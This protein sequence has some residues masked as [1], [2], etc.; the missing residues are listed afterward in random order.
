M[1]RRIEKNMWNSTLFWLGITCDSQ[2]RSFQLLILFAE[3]FGKY[4]KTPSLSNHTRGDF[5]GILFLRN[6]LKADPELV[7]VQN[8]GRSSVLFT[9]IC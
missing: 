5:M 2:T 3:N 4:T 9:I 8:L 6:Y 7:S 1:G